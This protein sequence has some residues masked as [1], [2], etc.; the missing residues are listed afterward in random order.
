MAKLGLMT[1]PVNRRPYVS[2]HRAAA[3][4]R[5]RVRVVAAAREL[6]AARGWEGT[7]IAEVARR[8][9]V[10][11]DTVY[12]TIGRKP[13]LLR[14]VIDTVLGEGRGPVPA[15]QRRYVEDVRAVQDARSKIAVYAGALG[16]VM[17]ETAPLLL[18]LRDAGA[19]DPECARA[20]Q[21]V[22]ERRAR[23]MRLLAADLRVTGQVR[24]D[25]EDETVAD[26]VWAA[27]SPEYYTLLHSRGW[28]VEQYVDHLT[29]LWCRLL[30]TS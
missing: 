29:D 26:L 23:N 1:P 12:A 25:L 2:A 3:A 28:S 14:E 9:G 21:E 8:A 7:E 30:L 15:E 5:T 4:A 6:F 27:N 24:A 20:W 17:P 19:R 22:V 18:A 11:V 10:S 13:M 16:R